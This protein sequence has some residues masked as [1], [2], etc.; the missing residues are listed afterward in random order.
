MSKV[1]ARGK[2]HNK[3]KASELKLAK[4]KGLVAESVCNKCFGHGKLIGSKGHKAKCQ[5]QNCSCT[6]VVL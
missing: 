4:K 1:E 2:L 5:Y 3:L 6:N